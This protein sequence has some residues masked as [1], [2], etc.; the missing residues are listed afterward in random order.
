MADNE[1]LYNQPLTSETPYQQNDPAQ[2]Q[3][4]VQVNQPVNNA[5]Y[6]TQWN[7]VVCVISSAFFIVGIIASSLMLTTGIYDKVNIVLYLSFIPLIFTVVGSALGSCSNLYASINISSASRTIT[8]RKHKV[9]FCFND[10]VVIKINDLQQVI[11]Q[12]DNRT[13]YEENGNSYNAFEVIFK[14]I[15]GREVKGCTGMIN[16]NGEGTRVYQIIRNALPPSIAFGGDLA[17]FN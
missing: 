3:Q 4:A 12:T 11:V 7:R 9:C 5:N 16:K 13:H 1:N 15:D 2:F 6:S 8:I 17:N 14:L 10:K